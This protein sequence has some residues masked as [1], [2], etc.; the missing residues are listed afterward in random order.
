MHDI[1]VLNFSSFVY[2]GIYAWLFKFFNGAELFLM[3]VLFSSDLWDM[4]F[5][6]FLDVGLAS[7]GTYHCSK[8]FVYYHFLADT[9]S[10]HRSA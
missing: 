8:S 7:V 10:L 3:F 6:P 2:S 9:N 4:V 1:N 5:D